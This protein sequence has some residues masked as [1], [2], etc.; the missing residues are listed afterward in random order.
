MLPITLLMFATQGPYCWPGR[1]IL[2]RNLGVG[3]ACFSA[4]GPQLC[5]CAACKP[6]T[7][8]CVRACS[9]I[10]IIMRNRI[11]HGRALQCMG[12]VHT[13]C[14]HGG[15][16][17][18]SVHHVC[19]LQGVLGRVV[20]TLPE[21]FFEQ[22]QARTTGLQEGQPRSDAASQIRP[23]PRPASHHPSGIIAAEQ[24]ASIRA[25]NH[26]RATGT[27]GRRWC[28]HQVTVC[29]MDNTG[30]LEKNP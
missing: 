4:A 24:T 22:W 23:R 25:P 18:A 16:F 28:M 15:A 29:C 27:A 8:C 17:H 13:R 26:R 30:L 7:T 9:C 3:S 6:V 20:G 21:W 12:P 5:I 1:C 14:N 19:E 2:S 11:M 10:S